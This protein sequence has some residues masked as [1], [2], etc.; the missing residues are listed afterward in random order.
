MVLMIMNDL[1]NS[2]N[3]FLQ[4]IV[5]NQQN[6]LVELVLNRSLVGNHLLSKP[7]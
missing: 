5:V 1:I 7:N 2:E 3:N 4:N 6:Q